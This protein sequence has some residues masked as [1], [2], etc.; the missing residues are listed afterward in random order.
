VTDVVE[1]TTVKLA[2]G[3]RQRQTA[4]DRELRSSVPCAAHQDCGR[5]AGWAQQWPQKLNLRHS[6]QV[7]RQKHERMTRLVT[8]QAPDAI[9]SL[10]YNS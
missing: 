5:T 6:R 10:S 7:S 9:R 3:A 2:M 8:E 4:L 1:V